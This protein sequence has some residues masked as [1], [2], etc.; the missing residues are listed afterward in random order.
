V[1][2]IAMNDR[3]ANFETAY[4]SRQEWSRRTGE[5]ADSVSAPPLLTGDRL[6]QTYNRAPKPVT[7]PGDGG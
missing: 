1:A 7:R 5:V 6:G 3:G 4:S 2:R